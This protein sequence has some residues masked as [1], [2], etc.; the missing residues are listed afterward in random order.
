MNN[1]SLR[2]LIITL[3][4]IPAVVAAQESHADESTG[5][6]PLFADHSVLTVSIEAPL[7]TLMRDLPNKHYLDGKFRLTGADGSEE[8]FDLKI[9][10][11]GNYRRDKEHC[12]FA[13]IRLNFRTKQVVG[14]AL[15]G[16]DKLKLV[17][18]CRNRDPQFV[19]YI[20][21]EYLVYRLLNAMTRKSFGVRLMQITYID[22]EG[23]G[24]MTKYG[25]VIEDDDDV[26]ARNG[27]QAVKTGDISSND[28][29]PA[30]QNFIHVF[31][32]MIGNTEYSL[33]KA[34]PDKSC[35]HNIDLLS[36][37]G[38]PPLTPLAYDFD[39]SGIVNAPYAQ[40][41]P[42]YNLRT[43]RQRLYK[44]RCS[45]NDIL[46]ETIQRFNDKKDVIFDIVDGF[47]L[48][49]ARSKRSAIRFLTTF[50]ETSSQP[51]LVQAR[52]VEQCNAPEFN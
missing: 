10:T 9:R 29:E 41:N 13:P 49:N 8:V 44:G 52:L 38:L 47:E 45:N 5:V 51:E 18:H 26:A 20:L 36:V 37:T 23:A 11:R 33:V 6:A 28:L 48:L 22:T 35:C 32:Y 24:R 2:S 25:F 40:P 34:E 30:D 17:T 7:K 12:D 43:V 50:F 31:Q 46:E 1:V 42:K 27:M 39:F 19:Q 15:E 14:T 16:Q 21:R 3:A 4:L